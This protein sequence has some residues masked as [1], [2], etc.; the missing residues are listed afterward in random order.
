MKFCE[1]VKTLREKA[2]LTQKEF[3]LKLGV[4]LRTVTNYET[5]DRYP[6]KREL[7][8]T[9]AEVLSCPVN[10]LLSED[11][12]FML[13]ASERFGL[14]GEND[15]K[16]ILFEARALFAGGDIPEEDARAFIDELERL[17]LDSKERAKR[18]APKGK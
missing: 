1:K 3:A 5:G 4:S 14:K 7:Y 15:A 10:Y 9:M 13:N 18:F 6:K 11:E 17:Y 16:R 12:E 2:G 8:K